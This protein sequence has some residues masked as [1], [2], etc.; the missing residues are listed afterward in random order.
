MGS[1]FRRA[2]HGLRP[3]IS[4]WCPWEPSCSHLPSHPLG[5]EGAPRGA[6]GARG[7]DR[8][9]LHVDGQH[10]EIPAPLWDVL[11][12]HPRN[13]G[14]VTRRSVWAPAARIQETGRTGEGP[15]P[16]VGRGSACSP[17]GPA[18]RLG[19]RRQR[20]IRRDGKMHVLPSAA[21]FEFH[22]NRTEAK[23]TAGRCAVEG[24]R[25]QVTAG[26]RHACPFLRPEPP[27]SPLNASTGCS[28]Q[29][30]HSPAGEWGLGCR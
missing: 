2:S 14:P 26:T 30:R 24:H 28:R 9:D 17:L 19:P 22:G 15:P 1:P 4:A 12:C 25:A 10:S 5:P 6:G 3:Q 21:L 27:G 18:V 16:P 8:A 23:P 20:G 13:L 7:R 29:D 11:P